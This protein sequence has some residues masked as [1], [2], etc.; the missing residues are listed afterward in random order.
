MEWSDFLDRVAQ[1]AIGNE[2]AKAYQPPR[3]PV[4]QTSAGLSYVEGKPVS[5]IAETGKIFGIPKM[6]VIGGA[7][8][9]LIGGYF[10]M[11]KK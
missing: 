10:L 5:G 8:A 7:V 1:D 11:R 4:A 9:L 6:V 3:P 2:A